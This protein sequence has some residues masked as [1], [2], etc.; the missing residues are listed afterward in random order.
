MS[1]AT[2]VAAAALAAVLTASGCVEER[3]SV[4]DNFHVAETFLS[5]ANPGAFR[6]ARECNPSSLYLKISIQ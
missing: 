4:A 5:I 3:A 2:L 1:N 6:L